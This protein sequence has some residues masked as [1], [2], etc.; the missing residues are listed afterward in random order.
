M[1]SQDRPRDPSSFVQ[2]GQS[3]HEGSGRCDSQLKAE[4]L[5]TLVQRQEDKSVLARGKGG[6]GRGGGQ[7]CFF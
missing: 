7:K 4:G 5:T 6:G 1:K 3:P 2:V